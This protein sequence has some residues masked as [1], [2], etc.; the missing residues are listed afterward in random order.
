MKVIAHRGNNHNLNENRENGLLSCLQKDY[1]DGIEFDIQ[2]T[3]DGYFV[4]AH[5][6]FLKTEHKIYSIENSSWRELQK[7]TFIKSGKPFKV[8]E[9]SSFLQKITSDKILLMECKVRG[10]I[11]IYYKKLQK[12]LK[13]YH[14]LNL[15]ICSFNEEILSLFSNQ[16][17]K[18]MIKTRM[19]NFFKNLDSYDFVSINNRENIQKPYFLWTI[20][21]IELLPKDSYF[22]GIITDKPR[23]FQ[24]KVI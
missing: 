6:N 7:E 11:P 14:H 12:V 13:K 19:I 5:S 16:F 9:L 18:G 17:P 8:T 21:K 24:N 3:K 2:M 1:I 15:W 20:N 4:L 23:L 10:S 22:L